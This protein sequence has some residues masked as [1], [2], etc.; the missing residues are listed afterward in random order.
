MTTHASFGSYWRTA[1][2]AMTL[3]L[4]AAVLPGCA[5]LTTYNK[6]V[7]LDGAH[8]LAIDVK[9][10]VVFSQQRKNKDG[11]QIGVVTCAEPSPDALTVVSASLGGSLG[12]SAP[13]GN[14]TA[15]LAAALSESGAFVGLRTQSIQLLRDAMYRL[16]E[17]YA[18]GAVDDNEYEGMQRRFQS[19]MMGLIAIEQLTRPVVAGQALLT[20]SAGAQGGAGAG[21]AQVQAAQGKLTE[22]RAKVTNAETAVD[23]K[24]TALKESRTKLSTE[25]ARL[26]AAPDGEKA[27]IGGEVETARLK[28]QQDELAV[29]GAIRDLERERKA[30]SEAQFS[31]QQAESKAVASTS[32][33]GAL[34]EISRATS[35][36]SKHL[37]ESVEKIVEEINA[38]YMRDT[39]FNLY[40][41]M[42]YRQQNAHPLSRD[43]IAT[44][45]D[46]K[47]LCSELMTGQVA[48]EQRKDQLKL[49]K[50]RLSIVEKQ[51]ELAKATK[52]QEVVVLEVEKRPVTPKA[53][54]TKAK[55]P[56][57]AEAAPTEKK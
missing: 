35:D 11:V 22:Q 55:E 54:K 50:A 9:Q 45:G 34:G 29:R 2:I 46:L 4:G 21:D 27:S 28:V 24:Q 25:Q 48:A 33:G 3:A 51:I 38:S 7:K 14:T 40:A 16:C 13:Q 57:R 32:G 52:S 49:E 15:N 41:R 26:K 47:K 30:Q 19:T 53:P 6:Q 5:H 17:A 42:V 12:L 39:C 23:E 18:A 44:F 1:S 37:A 56:A 8:S 36:S 10:R 43:S 20:S 31:L